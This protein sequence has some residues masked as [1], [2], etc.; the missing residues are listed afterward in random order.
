[1]SAG[2]EKLQIED[3]DMKTNIQGHKT[4]QNTLRMKLCEITERTAEVAGSSGDVKVLREAFDRI[5]TESK[6][7]QQS[8]LRLKLTLQRRVE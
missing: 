2:L 3:S 8:L 5:L 7:I 6:A 4:R 1:V